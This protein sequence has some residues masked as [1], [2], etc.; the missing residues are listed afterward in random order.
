MELIK[1]FRWHLKYDFCQLTLNKLLLVIVFSMG[2]GQISQFAQTPKKIIVGTIEAESENKISGNLEVLKGSDQGTIIPVTII[3]G[4]KPG[5]VLALIAGIHGTEYIPVLTLQR[6]AANLNPDEISGAI[7]MV[8][9]ANIPS[10]KK[11][12]VYFNPVDNKNL[13]RVFPGNK[14]GTITER[15]ADIITNEVIDQADYL[16]DFHG[17]EFNEELCNLIFYNYDCSDITVGKSSKF[18]ADAFGLNYI[19]PESFDIVPD[20][21]NGTYCYLTAVRRGV[22]AITVEIGDRGNIDIKSIITMEH[23]IMNVLKALKMVKGNIDEQNPVVYLT[24][25]HTI[26][27]HTDGIFYAVVDCGQTVSKSSLL[28]YATDYLG[29]RTENFYAPITGIIVGK[30]D[31]PAI[32]KGE[33]IFWIAIPADSF[34]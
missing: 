25:I 32:N 4:A 20:S 11:R 2:I 30:F 18:L 33:E 24:D 22:P 1:H 21:I 13:N 9:I 6:I 29:N 34:K 26:E 5:P 12:T 23:G 16:I 28:G 27:S 15:I 19:V 8:H 10:Y 17:G 31:T 14:E 3:N 7:I